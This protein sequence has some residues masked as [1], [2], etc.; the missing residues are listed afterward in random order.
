[1]CALSVST[2]I[3]EVV[4]FVCERKQHGLVGDAKGSGGDRGLF[5]L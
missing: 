1:M 5:G 2:L 4:F 3:G